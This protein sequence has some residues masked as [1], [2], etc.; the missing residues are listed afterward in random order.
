MRLRCKEQVMLGGQRYHHRRKF[1]AL[2]T[3][4]VAGGL[5]GVRGGLAAVPQNWS[6]AMAKAGDLAVLFEHFVAGCP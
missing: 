2:T 5:A 4:V 1:R 3:G 6:D